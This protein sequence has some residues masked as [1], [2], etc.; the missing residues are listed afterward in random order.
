MSNRVM[1][2]GEDHQIWCFKNDVSHEDLDDVL[3]KASEDYPCAMI[4]PEVEQVFVFDDDDYE[5]DD[6]EW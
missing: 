4:W 1:C 3:K 6:G 2:E 5:E